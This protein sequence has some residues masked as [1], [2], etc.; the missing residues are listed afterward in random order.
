MPPDITEDLY[1]LIR[2]SDEVV[3]ST[4]LTIVLRAIPPG[5]NDAGLPCSRE[6][7]RAARTALEV[8]RNC[9]LKYRKLI[10][11]SMWTDYLNWF[12]THHLSTLNPI[13]MIERKMLVLY[14]RAK[15]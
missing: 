14:F 6:C 2:V 15:N 1:E 11:R 10:T 12:V 4:L 5:S 13:L 3:L 8:H 7:V 9:S